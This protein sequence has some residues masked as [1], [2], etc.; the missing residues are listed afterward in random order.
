[1]NCSTNL[2]FLSFMRIPA[3]FVLFLVQ[4]ASAFAACEDRTHNEIDYVICRFDPQTADIRL[5]L[6]NAEDAPYRHFNWVEEAL[7]AQ[8]ETLTFAMNAGMYHQDR[9]PVG[10][11]VENGEATGKLVTG[12][13]YGN[14]HL[15]PNGVFF[16]DARGEAQVM[17]SAAFARAP[18]DTVR[19]ATQS[20]PMLVIDGAIH[21][22][23][24]PDSE[25]LKRRNGVGVTTG[26][27]TLF[28]LADTPVRFFDFATFFRDELQTPNALY[29]DGTI[30]R[31]YS[32]ELGRNDPGLGMGPIVGVVTKR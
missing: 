31:I 14:F 26:G 24:L 23:F 15:L 32:P 10:L 21:P 1:M 2:L 25:S 29:L 20:G 7:N 8:G 22:R 28:V 16:V 5:M 6:N 18:Q 12:A 11:Y 27:E 30:S 4:T 13:G 3:F 17:E 9:S 19:Y